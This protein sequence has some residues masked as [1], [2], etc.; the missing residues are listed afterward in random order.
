MESIMIPIF[1]AA[2]AISTIDKVAGCAISEWKHLTSAQQT[3]AKPEP[4]ADSGAFAA[5]LGTLGVGK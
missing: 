4:K 5:L 3:V 2:S 1:A